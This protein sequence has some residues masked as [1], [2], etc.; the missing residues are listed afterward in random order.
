MRELEET[1]VDKNRTWDWVKMSDLK[2]RTEALTFAAQKQALRTNYVKFQLEKTVVSIIRMY[3][4]KGE[5]VSHLASE[6][7]KPA[8]GEYKRRYDNIARTSQWELCRL[9]E[10][11]TA[12][13]WFEHQQSSVVQTD[14]TKVLW[15]FNIQCDHIIEVR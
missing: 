14:K 8:Q 11:D 3:N 1:G 10:L 6:C 9:Y 7:S 12:D 2:T 4:E 15:N 13:K 5:S